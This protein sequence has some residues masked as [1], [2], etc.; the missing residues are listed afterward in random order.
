MGSLNAYDLLSL[1]KS[2]R[3]SKFKLRV[4]SGLAAD[5]TWIQALRTKSAMNEG[6]RGFDNDGEKVASSTNAG[7]IYSR[8]Q[9]SLSH[10]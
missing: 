3:A 6:W 2:G 4:G 9:G 1:E 7:E 8:R 10:G 5:L